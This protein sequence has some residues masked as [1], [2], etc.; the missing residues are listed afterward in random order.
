MKIII[1][2]TPAEFTNYYRLRYEVLRQ[3]WQQPLGSERA[4]DDVTATHAM[5][6]NEEQEALGVGRL[7]QHSPEEAQI[8]FM[9]IQPDKQGLGLGNLLLQYF[10]TID[11]Q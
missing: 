7:H 1:P 5:L 2:A 3:P 11:R 6:I 8:R 9:A 4:E 10:E